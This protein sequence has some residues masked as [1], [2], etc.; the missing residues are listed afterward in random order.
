VPRPTGL[1]GDGARAPDQQSAD[2]EYRQLFTTLLEKA[3]DAVF[4]IRGKT[5]VLANSRYS[6]RIGM[7]L[8]E[9]VGAE[10]T[11]YV[12][13]DL[14][15]EEVR[16][17][18]EQLA[19]NSSSWID[20]TTAL[21][22]DGS[23]IYVELNATRIRYEGQDA[24]LVI[25]SDV[26]PIKKAEAEIVLLSQYQRTLIEHLNI[27]VDVLDRNGNVIVWNR[28]AEEISGYSKD[29]VVG[30]GKIWEYLYPDKRY[31]DEIYARAR[32][33]IEERDAVHG[34]ETQIVTRLGYKKFIS[35]YSRGFYDIN[36][37]PV[38]SVAIGLDITALRESNEAL[39]R[40]NQ[41][42]R[43]AYDQTIE[44]WSR[45]MDLRDKE[46]EG[47][48]RRVTEITVLLA[49]SLAIPEDEIVHLRRGALLHDIG[50]MGVPDAILLKPGPLTD[51]EWAIMRQHP[52]LAYEMLLPIAYLRPALDIPYS[53]HEKWDGTGYPRGLKGEQI[54]L[55]ARI[56]AVADV[57]DALRSSRP[58]RPAW[59]EA[60][61]RDHILALSGAH[62]DP[63]VVTAFLQL[64]RLPT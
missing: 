56:F 5:I 15:S 12:R 37:S 51:A 38:G 36:G 30:H 47:H 33:I 49:R 22:K 42:L 48:T 55:A 53:H 63:R 23:E 17:F 25:A 61:V 3:S 21:T 44:G 14:V 50:K 27:W 58:Y 40:A 28:A 52:A 7:P 1:D 26:T 10:F 20:R 32:R 46:T 45:A 13:P 18:E 64:G 4:I 2:Q 6:E 34:F 35:W 31:R 39:N 8:E 24:V 29:E 59:P 16:K 60:R 57:W 41:S 19:R 62:F 43:Q 9:I 54:P 11:R